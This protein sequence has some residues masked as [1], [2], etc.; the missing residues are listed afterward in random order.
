M[1]ETDEGISHL[2]E[3][4][5]VDGVD[6]IFVGP[7]DLAVSIGAPP[8]GDARVD[9]RIE[10]I[11]KRCGAHGVVA[12]IFCASTDAAV[13]WSSQGFK[14]LAVQSD[15]RLLREAA[16]AALRKAKGEAE[17]GQR[18]PSSGYS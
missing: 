14:M 1:I 3:I 9:S 18:G 10:G 4:L 16:G 7:A 12:G 17:V 8:S 13:R 15:V 2:D 11:G 6:A 5:A